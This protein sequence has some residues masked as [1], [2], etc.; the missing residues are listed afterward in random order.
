MVGGFKGQ[1]IDVMASSGDKPPI[2]SQHR[3]N[4]S[5]EL[6]IISFKYTDKHHVGLVVISVALLMDFHH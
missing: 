2:L 4:R 1:V 3:D 5:P 6:D